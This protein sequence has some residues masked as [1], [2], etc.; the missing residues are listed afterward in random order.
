M[1]FDPRQD[2][3]RGLQM[4]LVEELAKD[5]WTPVAVGDL[6]LDRQTDVRWG[7]Q[8]RVRERM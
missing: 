5:G 8:M 7:D 4:L 3:G 2:V 1:A 6:M